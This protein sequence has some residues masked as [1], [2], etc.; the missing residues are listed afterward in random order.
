MIHIL[1]CIGFSLLILSISAA[2]AA[3]PIWTSR[4]LNKTEK[5]VGLLALLLPA[6]AVFLLTL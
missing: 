2:C 5:R 3:Q 6:I 4:N 1:H